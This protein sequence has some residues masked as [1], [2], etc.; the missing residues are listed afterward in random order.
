MQVK[1]DINDSIA[2]IRMS[3]KGTIIKKIH[4]KQQNKLTK[5][6]YKYNKLKHYVHKKNF[7]W[8]MKHRKG[9]VLFCG[10]RV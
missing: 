8:H 1:R 2:W 3:F 4:T 9:I 7:F 6:N 5:Q 10:S